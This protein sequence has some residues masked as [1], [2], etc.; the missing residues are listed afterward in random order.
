MRAESLLLKL[1][2]ES[3]DSNTRYSALEA[4]QTAGTPAVIPA[5][6][7]R[8]PEAPNQNVRAAIGVIIRKPGG[9]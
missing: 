3:G 6:R 5:L 9:G 2:Q 8:L 4:L 7:E 1:A